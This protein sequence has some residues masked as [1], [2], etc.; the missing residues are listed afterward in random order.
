LYSQT[1]ALTAAGQRDSS[2]TRSPGRT[3]HVQESRR[4]STTCL[5]ATCCWSTAPIVSGHP[6]DWGRAAQPQHL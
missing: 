6:D 1:D 2:R 5:P 3:H 4:A